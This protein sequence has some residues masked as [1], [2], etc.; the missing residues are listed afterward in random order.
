MKKVFWLAPVVVLIAFIG[1]Y[2]QS[3]TE[4]EQK[5]EAKTRADVEERRVKAAKAKADQDA[6]AEKRRLDTEAKKKRDAEEKARAEAAAKH[7]E[8]IQYQREFAKRETSRFNN[9]VK[10]LKEAFEAEKKGKDEADKV[11]ADNKKEKEF[12]IEY[13]AKARANEK[14]YKD[15]LVR[16][17]ELEEARA[18]AE[19]AAAKVAKAGT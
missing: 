13:V 16:L 3:R 12:L 6:A 18:K 9:V 11:I 19:A 8:E 17:Q 14:I 10:E 4:I 7:L 1:L 5:A 15:L 2:S